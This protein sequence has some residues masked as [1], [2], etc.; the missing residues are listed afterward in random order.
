ML[1]LG[2]GVWVHTPLGKFLITYSLGQPL[3][4]FI[5]ADWASS[6]LFGKDYDNE[7]PTELQ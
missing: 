2:K 5:L 4:A 1:M 6:P 7:V 3:A